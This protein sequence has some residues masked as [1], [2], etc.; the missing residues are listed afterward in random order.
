ME[1]GLQVRQVPKITHQGI[2]TRPLQASQQCPLLPDRGDERATT[3]Q[4]SSQP[5]LWLMGQRT[6]IP[7][8]LPSFLRA[9]T[10]NKATMAKRDIP[11]LRQVAQAPC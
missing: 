2:K 7:V 10:G 5:A 4:K 6:R 9:S 11:K 8:P 3:S 1:N